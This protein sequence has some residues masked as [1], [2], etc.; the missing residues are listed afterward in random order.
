MAAV[1]K[2]LVIDNIT[3]PVHLYDV[4]R[5]AD[6]L[7]AQAYRTED[8]VLHRKVIGTYINYDVKVGIE[9]ST[10][11]Y[12]RLFYHLS[13]PVNSHMVKLPN[14]SEPQERYISSVQD[15]ILR[16]EDDGTIY[17]DLSFKVTCIS[18]TRKASG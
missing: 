4:V 12:D 1:E 13:E 14:E 9:L 3:Y 6:Q 7:D 2:Y 18:P 17:K 10:E 8:G 16:V 15:G 5:R 11:L